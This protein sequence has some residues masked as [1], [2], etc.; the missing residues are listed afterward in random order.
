M[1]TGLKL[2]DHL[3]TTVAA[4]ER[5]SRN[6]LEKLCRSLQEQLAEKTRELESAQAEIAWLGFCR[7]D[8]K[9]MI[10]AANANCSSLEKYNRELKRELTEA[11]KEAESLKSTV[12]AAKVELG[13]ESRKN[14]MLQKDIKALNQRAELLNPLVDIGVATRL[15]FLQH[16]RRTIHRHRISDQDAIVIKNGNVAAHGG[17]GIAD[18][19]M[20][21]AYLVTKGHVLGQVFKDLYH[22]EPAEYLNQ[23]EIKML[24]RMLDCEATITTVKINNKL[25]E[26]AALRKDHHHLLENLY[27]AQTKSPSITAWEE[28]HNNKR[29]LKRLEELT[30]EIV[31]LDMKTG[32]RRKKICSV[33]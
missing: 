5:T 21:K 15:R 10:E 19:A 29:W 20:F 16:A 7:S 26:S 17:N 25:K 28:N 31:R 23:N 8:L 11:K 4:A 14:S 27:D 12:S 33:S 3:S 22:C 30:A 13:R 32:P 9:E 18:A 24:R 6:Q 1:S 2:S